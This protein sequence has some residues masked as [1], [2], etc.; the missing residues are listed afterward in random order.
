M[1]GECKKASRHFFVKMQD[2]LNKMKANPTKK[3]F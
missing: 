1:A 3:H 2:C